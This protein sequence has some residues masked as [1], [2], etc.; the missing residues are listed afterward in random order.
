[1]DVIVRLAIVAVSVGLADSL[2][3]ETIGPA[4]FFATVPER[5]RRVTEFTVGVF[6]VN[7]AVGI[8]L[9]SGPGGWLLKFVPRPQGTAR[10]VVELVAGV[11][12]LACA[13]ALWLG[14]RRLMQRDLPTPSGGSA[15]VAGVSIAA[16]GLPTAIPYFALIA[17]LIAS[18]ATI[19]QEIFLLTLYNVAFVAPLLAILVILVAAGR[20]ADGP[21]Q[22]IGAWVRRQW[23]VVLAVLLLV[24]GSVLVLLG[25]AGLV[26]Q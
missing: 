6:G 7:L 3:L 24:L 23:P 10:H 18:S 9:V 4:L 20:R 1:M 22:T 12:L 16:I 26:G 5:V 11:V 25:G 21:L 15:L 17:A 14:R 2:N 13:G 19:P 8:V